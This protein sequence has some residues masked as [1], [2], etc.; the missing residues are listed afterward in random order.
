MEEDYIIFEEMKKKDANSFKQGGHEEKLAHPRPI[1]GVYASLYEELR[2]KCN[3]SNFMHPYN[4]ELVKLSNA[5]YSE[6]EVNKSD[7]D[8]LKRIRRRAV[9]ELGIKIS[10]E[11]L[12]NLL[13]NRLDP[14]KYVGNRELVD[15]ANYFY[16]QML[17]N[18]DNIEV[19]EQI[20]KSRQFK[21]LAAEYNRQQKK[22]N[23]QKEAEYNNRQQK[24][25][26]MQKEEVYSTLKCFVLVL[27]GLV[28]LCFLL[29][30]IP[31]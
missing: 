20:E 18:A 19:L 22:L 30:S 25:L 10:T 1:M 17:C 6:M 5:L 12:Y 7:M 14:S 29:M 13:S 2:Q 23:M 27:I 3:P 15:M 31:H 24:R 16:N 4:F 21:V 28:G 8:A 9:A 11:K 26:N